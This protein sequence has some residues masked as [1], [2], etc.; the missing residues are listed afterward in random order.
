MDEDL[1]AIVNE[2]RIANQLTMLMLLIELN[3]AEYV[4]LRSDCIAEAV[5]HAAKEMG[6]KFGFDEKDDEEDEDLEE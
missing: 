3:D 6:Y 5:C 1:K 4:S 2:L